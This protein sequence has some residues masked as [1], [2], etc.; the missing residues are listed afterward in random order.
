MQTYV[1]SLLGMEQMGCSWKR[2]LKNRMVA[3]N[4]ARLKIA[5]ISFFIRH[6]KSW[7]YGWLL[8]IKRSLFR[9]K[10]L[11]T[12]WYKF[13]F[14]LMDLRSLADV[15]L[16]VFFGQFKVLIFLHF[17]GHTDDNNLL[18]KT[19]F[20]KIVWAQRLFEWT[21]PSFTCENFLNRPP[22]PQKYHGAE[23]IFSKSLW[24]KTWGT[25]L[26]RN[27]TPPKGRLPHPVYAGN[28]ITV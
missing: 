19:L 2:F 3:V 14:K 17:G 21:R 23:N 26:G 15:Q 25:L 9:L 11:C 18:L 10:M 22:T 1:F 8:M 13:V 12:V 16:F 28:G 4:Q 7:K 27:Y 5:K 20:T 24:T 6:F